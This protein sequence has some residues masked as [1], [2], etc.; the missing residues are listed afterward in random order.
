MLFH[1]ES[2][3]IGVNLRL[4]R[5]ISVENFCP[6][7]EKWDKSVRKTNVGNFSNNNKNN[8]NGNDNNNLFQ[9]NG[10]KEVLLLTENLK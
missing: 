8:D 6:K 4:L 3:F 9:I 10:K 7:F 2:C 1:S 5:F